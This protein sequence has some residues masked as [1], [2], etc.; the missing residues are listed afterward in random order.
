MLISRN[1]IKNLSPY[2]T[3]HIKRFGEYVI[4]L[5]EIPEPINRIDI[6]EIIEP[7]TWC[8]KSPS[9]Y[10]FLNVIYTY[11]SIK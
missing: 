8:K 1:D 5:D 9:S 3:S 7:I 2:M 6:E 11:A 4:D 10:R